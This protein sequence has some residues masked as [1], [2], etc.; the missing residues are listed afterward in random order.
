VESETATIE[1]VAVPGDCIPMNRVS[2]E[3]ARAD[4]NACSFSSAR[5]LASCEEAVHAGGPA[6]V[7]DSDPAS[8]PPSAPVS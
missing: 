7:P 2:P 1:P 4:V 8:V 3:S 5:T 6:S